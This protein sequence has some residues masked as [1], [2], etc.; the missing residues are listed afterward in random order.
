M[1][2]RNV[3]AGKIARKMTASFV[4]LIGLQVSAATACPDLVRQVDDQ[5]RAQRDALSAWYASVKDRAGYEYRQSVRQL[6]LERKNAYRLCP[7]ERRI[8]LASN[9][10]RR[11]CLSRDYNAQLRSLREDYGC[12][13]DRLYHEYEI[14]R[15][16]AKESSRC[17]CGKCSA[18]AYGG[19]HVQPG[20]APWVET[21]HRGPVRVEHDHVEPVPRLQPPLNHGGPVGNASFRGRNGPEPWELLVREILSAYA[22]SR[23]PRQ[24]RW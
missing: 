21:Y 20:P 14:A 19:P 23:N 11:R 10:E 12:R 22:N 1:N 18:P 9:T 6:D 3:I 15:R 4:A 8:V 5:Y 17:V 16:A 2:A 7:D 13:K 24:N